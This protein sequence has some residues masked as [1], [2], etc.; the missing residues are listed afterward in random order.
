M[1]FIQSS[2]SIQCT[3]RDNGVGIQ[4]QS[5]QGHESKGLKMIREKLSLLPGYAENSWK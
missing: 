1:A 4:K 3:V 2:K 5:Q